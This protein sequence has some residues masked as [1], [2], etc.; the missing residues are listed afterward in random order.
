M[1]EGA[2][3]VIGII[4]FAITVAGAVM[5]GGVAFTKAAIEQETP[6][7][8]ELGERRPALSIPSQFSDLLP[9]KHRPDAAPD[10]RL[11]RVSPERTLPRSADFPVP[12]SEIP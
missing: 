7:Q 2:L 4:I 5:A 3:F 11:R 9:G 8:P 6:P 10:R 12:A 1:N